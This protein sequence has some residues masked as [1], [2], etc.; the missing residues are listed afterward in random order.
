LIGQMV[1]RSVPR[2]VVEVTR[3]LGRG[4]ADAIAAVLKATYSGTGINT[5]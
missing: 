3:R 1:K 2:R 4:T 5:A